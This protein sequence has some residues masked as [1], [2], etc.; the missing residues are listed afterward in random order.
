MLDSA[1]RTGERVQRE[2]ADSLVTSWPD[3]P[4]TPAFARTKVIVNMLVPLFGGVTIIGAENIPAHGPVILA[5]NHRANIDPPYL[6][7]LTTRQQYYMAK[8][9]LFKVPV[10][11]TYIAAMGAYP[12]KRGAAD[13]AAL[14]QSMEYLKRGRIITIF[15]EGTRSENGS[16]GKAEK[17]FALIAKQTGAPIVPVAV[18]G[19][20]LVLPRGS[21][22]I[23]RHRVTLVVGTPI[24]AS[25]ILAESPVK[26]S[27]ALDYIGS[28]VMERI[29][30]LIA[31]NRCD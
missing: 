14:R 27:D 5:P 13:R 29:A 3:D 10:F 4:C 31:A 15:P 18:Q 7:T 19:T 12:V 11:G 8:E 22:R 24:T 6:T 23:H 16:L 26:G 28:V 9:E 1:A 25:E 20:E 17:G 2:D 30:Q 21:K